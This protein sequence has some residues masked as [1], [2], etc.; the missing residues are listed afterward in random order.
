MENNISK[1]QMLIDSILELDVAVGEINNKVNAIL[2][3]NEETKEQKKEKIEKSKEDIYNIIKNARKI[4]E[5]LGI[6]IENI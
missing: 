4:A 1:R 6:N 3:N 2:Y 5:S